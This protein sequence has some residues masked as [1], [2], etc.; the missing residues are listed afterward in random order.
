VDVRLGLPRGLGLAATIN[1]DFGQVEVDP[2][3]INLTAF[4]TLYPERRPFF[5]EGSGTFQVG[6][7]RAFSGSSGSVVHTRR[8]GR[9]P[10]GSVSGEFVDAPDQSTILAAAKVGGQ[11]PGGWSLGVMD[12][13]TDR[14][15]ARFLGPEGIGEALVEPRTNYFVGRARRDWSEGG[16]YLGGI[17]TATNRQLSGQL[18]RQLRGAA[19]LAG[20]DGAWSWDDRRWTLSGYL[21]G[22]RVTGSESAIAF[23]QRSSARYFARPDASHVELDPTRTSLSGHDGAIALAKGGG[24]WSGSLRY[25]E[26][27]PGFE[28]NDLGF[29]TRA[30]SRSLSATLTSR[31]ETPGRWARNASLTLSHVTGW[32]FGGDRFSQE[33]ALRGIASLPSYWEIGGRL[34]AS[35][36]VVQDRL[37]RGG[38]L[39]LRPRQWSASGSIGTDTRRALF[40]YAGGSYGA[41][42]LGD[43]SRTVYAGATYRP[44]DAVEVSVAP[45]LY[46]QRD[47]RQYVKAVPDPLAE[48]TFG[49]RYVFARLDQTTLSVESRLSWTFTPRLSLQL[50]LQPLLNGSDFSDY[51]ELGQA[52]SLSLPVYGRDRGTVET[53]ADGLLRVD[54]DGSGGASPFLVGDGF[55]QVDFNVQSLRGNA[56]LRWEFRPGSA[57]FFVWQQERAGED[58]LARLDPRRDL[59]ALL[60]RPARNVFLVKGSWWI[61]A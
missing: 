56:V 25:D 29:R 49:R 26:T 43:F 22:S 15:S 13:L 14:E 17:A 41:S 12:A 10:Q 24:S 38:P 53:L 30:D 52:R 3:V 47:Q 6:Q 32:N 2:A 48:A 35:P 57:L 36:R 34:A 31:R 9:A 7:L 46:R 42:E 8:I 28:P 27:S 54:P 50:Y 44:S 45:H 33:T 4:E 21:V 51:K 18:E 5:V 61:G 23:T 55:R 40:G 39:A 59:D 11:L 20:A 60:A 37:T 1:P 58:R 19:Y 16:S